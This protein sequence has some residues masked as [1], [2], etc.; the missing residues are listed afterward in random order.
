[1]RNFIKLTICIL[2]AVFACSCSNKQLHL[3]S[4]SQA[5]N[6]RVDQEFLSKKQIINNLVNEAKNETKLDKNKIVEKYLWIQY[7][8]M[9]EDPELELLVSYR[10]EIHNGYFCV[11]D[12]K[13]KKYK[14]IFSCPW[15][16]EKMSGQ[17]IVVASGGSNIH[18]LTANIIHMEK[19]K[20]WFLWSAVLDKYDY[21]DPYKGIEVHGHYYVDT[22]NILHYSYKVEKTDKDA[23]VLNREYKEEFFI[24][25]RV[26]NKYK[27]KMH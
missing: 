13:D 3:V 20:L 25:D 22:N 4:S 1:M 15:A 11:Y 7:V 2:I 16:V 18:Q 17:E 24:W 10:Y 14:E 21:T 26:E 27:E 9:D 19:G 8:N 5:V 12:Y 6:N 23:V